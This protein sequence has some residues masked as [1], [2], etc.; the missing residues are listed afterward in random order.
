[1]KTLLGKSFINLD[2]HLPT[3][4]IKAYNNKRQKV[5][6]HL[7]LHHKK[8]KGVRLIQGERYEREAKTR[9]E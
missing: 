2:H 5:T 3:S 8:T 6:E 4:Q 9:G 1:M 7:G